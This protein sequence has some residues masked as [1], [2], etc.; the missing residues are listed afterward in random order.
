[1][2]PKRYPLNPWGDIDR[3][4]LEPQGAPDLTEP[5]GNR[6]QHVTL[7]VRGTTGIDLGRLILRC[8][9]ERER[10][11]PLAMMIDDPRV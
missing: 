2:Q 7:E 11:V 3:S 9:Y 8:T 6:E 5:L 1:M 10:Q 4:D